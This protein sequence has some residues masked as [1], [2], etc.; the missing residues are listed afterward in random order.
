[1]KRPRKERSDRSNASVK[2]KPMTTD[3][4]TRLLIAVSIAFLS[5]DDER[6]RGGPLPAGA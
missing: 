3:A 6:R 5:S 2:G 1:M 4:L